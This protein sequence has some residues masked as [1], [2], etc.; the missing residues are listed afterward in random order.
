MAF[1]E[2]KSREDAESKDI[3]RYLQMRSRIKLTAQSF[4]TF[5]DINQKLK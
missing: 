5:Y 3:T 1:N 4:L 2:M